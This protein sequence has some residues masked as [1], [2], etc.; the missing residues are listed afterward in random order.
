MALGEKV[1]AFLARLPWLPTAGTF[2][3]SLFVIPL[4]LVSVGIATIFSISLPG[5]RN[6][7]LPQAIFAVIGVVSMLLLTFLDYRALKP[8]APYLYGG[9]LLLLVLVLFVGSVQFGAQRWI[10][11][12]I[13]QIQPSELMKPILV[14][15]LAKLLADKSD[16]SWQRLIFILALTGIPILLVMRQPDAGSAI[17]LGLAL[18]PILF[19]SNLRR[20]QWSALIFMFLVS[21]PLFWGVLAPYQKQRLLTFINP[22]SD[23]FGAG[24]NV[25]QAQIAVGAGGLFGRGFGQGSQST[26]Q[27]LPVPHT[28]FIFAGVAEATG[29]VGSMVLILLFAFLIYRVIKLVWLSQDRFGSMLA[30][31]LGSLLLFSVFINIGM[32]LGLAPVTGIPLPFVSYGGSALIT[33][34][35]ILGILQSIYL[36]HKKIRFG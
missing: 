5:E 35:A 36:R 32:N 20:D 30:A 11:I 34:F 4:V 9:T 27:F 8:L 21:V 19:L 24:Y 33:N 18:L 16:V 3:W 14:I 31:G 2:D 6:L 23:P 28:D 25:L 10:D 7:A 12:G 26:L 1:R 22:R 15:F 17:L 13:F 29:F